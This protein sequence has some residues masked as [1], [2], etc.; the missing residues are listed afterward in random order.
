MTLMLSALRCYLLNSFDCIHRVSESTHVAG[1]I[2]CTWLSAEKTQSFVTCSSAAG[3]LSDH[4]LITH[5]H[6]SASVVRATTQVNGKR[7][8]RPLATPNPLTDRHKKVAH[9][10]TS[11]I[12]TDVR[13]FVT[14]PQGFL[15]P[16]C[17]KLRIKM[18]T[19]LLFW[20]FQ[21]PIA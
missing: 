1:H 17:A 13:N 12:S 4:A 20:F 10:I 8:I 11:W 3:V 19:R 15:F 14:I 5:S 6:D 9:V 7:E 2:L 21:R 16:V 18:F